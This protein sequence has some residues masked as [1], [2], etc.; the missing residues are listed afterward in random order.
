MFQLTAQQ[1]IKS[2]FSKSY[3]FEVVKTI[4]KTKIAYIPI[5]VSSVLFCGRLMIS[6]QIAYDLLVLGYE[7]AGMTAKAS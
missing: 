1:R 7:A 5:S 6:S 3:Q 4:H 2:Y